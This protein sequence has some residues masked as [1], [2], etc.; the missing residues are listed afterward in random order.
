[1]SLNSIRVPIKPLIFKPFITI[2]S[3]YIFIKV[4]CDL[5]LLNVRLE[6]SNV[7]LAGYLL[8]SMVPQKK[9]IKELPFKY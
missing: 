2:L 9:G 4:T 5:V 6:L 8:V 3:P 1:M 7:I